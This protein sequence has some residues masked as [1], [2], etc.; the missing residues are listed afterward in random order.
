MET[1]TELLVHTT[2]ETTRRVVSE[3]CFKSSCRAPTNKEPVCRSHE[4]EDGNGEGEDDAD[5][6]AGWS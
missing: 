6:E 1:Q 3:S 4:D 2:C 5:G